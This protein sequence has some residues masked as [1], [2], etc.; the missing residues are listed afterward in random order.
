M[1]DQLMARVN[2]I[3]HNDRYCFHDCLDAKTV[4]EIMY[5]S[6]VYSSNKHM[7]LGVRFVSCRHPKTLFESS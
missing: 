4:D 7:P 2:E 6:I 1:H 3:V 5:S